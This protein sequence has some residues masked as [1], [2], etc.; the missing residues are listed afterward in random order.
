MKKVISGTFTVN[1]VRD[2]ED[3]SPAPRLQFSCNPILFPASSSGVS[4]YGA[5]GVAVMMFVGN[6]QASIPSSSAITVGQTKPSGVT[7]ETVDIQGNVATFNTIVQAGLAE[8][9]FTGQ[10]SVRVTGIVGEKSYTVTDYITVGANKKGEKGEKGDPGIDPETVA[11]LILTTNL[12]EAV[13]GLLAQSSSGSR[14]SIEAIASALDSQITISA[15]DIYLNGRTWAQV[16]NIERLL[17]GEEVYDGTR[18][19]PLY[20]G[21]IIENGYIQVGMSGGRGTVNTT[22][23]TPNGIQCSHPY[24]STTGFA[25]LYDRAYFACPVEFYMGITLGGAGSEV[26]FDTYFDSTTGSYLNLTGGLC[27][28]GNIVRNS[29]YSNPFAI[30][31]TVISINSASLSING[32]TS[33]ASLTASDLS[34][35]DDASIGGSL[36]ASSMSASVLNMGSTGTISTGGSNALDIASSGSLGISAD[37]SLN[38]SGSDVFIGTGSTVGADIRCTSLYI[39]G[40]E[41]SSISFQTGDGKTV[42]V[43]NG[44]ITGIR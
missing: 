19:G 10:L 38:L 13:A 33:T 27:L 1:C 4:E 15:D 18:G 41:G 25:I 17:A 20:A 42:T 12:D 43:S 44:I 30:N 23:I 39:N 9:Y 26:F 40:K 34:V 35:S 22:I 21:T 31:S 36:S 7:V 11:K 28:T 14:A 3:G 6:T 8:D 37:G 29:S 16:V 5:I 2:G 32:R 24:S